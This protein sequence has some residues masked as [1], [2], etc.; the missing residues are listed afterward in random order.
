[1][2]IRL[3]VTTQHRA[4]GPVDVLVTA[5]EGT[6][7]EAL[8]GGLRAASGS[9]GSRFYI[10]DALLDEDTEL[11]TPPLLEGA[12]VTIDA[13]GAPS[14]PTSGLRL[15]V[16][17]GPD[18]G[19]VHLLGRG[20]ARL[21]RGADADVQVNDP[22][23]S[24]MHATLDIAP[25]WVTVA[26]LGSTN[27]TQL[28]R[29]PVH[30]EPTLLLPDAVLRIGESSLTIVS[31]AEAGGDPD[32]DGLGHLEVRRSPRQQI[33]PSP[34]HV[35]LPA[36]TG[37]RRRGRAAARRREASEQAEALA[38]AKARID[39][40]LTA[41]A[42]LRRAHDPDAAAL[43]V[44]ALERDRRL[45]E[46]R[47]NHP[48]AL[49]VRLGTADL[50]S[51]VTASTVDGGAIERL[52]V[53]D[54]PVTV[55]LR[56]TGPLGIV[57]A[58]V[59]A[60]GLVRSMLAQLAAAHSPSDL[61]IVVIS[62]GGG[63][64]W[65]FTRWLPHLLP[66]EAQDCRLLLGLD[67][68]QAAARAAELLGRVEFRRSE[69]G[70]RDGSGRWT[71]RLSVVLL[72]RG[73]DSEAPPG[74]VTGGRIPGGLQLPGLSA[75]EISR[76]L[77]AGPGVGVHAIC[78]AE[79][80]SALPAECDSRITITGEVGT[81][82]DVR[83]S[84][85][86][87][88]DNVVADLVS[89]AWAERFGRALAPLREATPGSR[90][91]RLPDQVRLLDL[92]KLDL[93]TPA[94]VAANWSAGG[95]VRATLGAGPQGPL[96]LDLDEDGPHV[97]VGGAPGAGKSEALRTLVTALAV[98]CPP[99]ELGLILIDGSARADGETEPGSSFAD[100]VTLPHVLAAFCELDAAKAEQAV[101]LLDHELERRAQ[102]RQ[103]QPAGTGR[104]SRPSTPAR[105]VVVVDEFVDLAERFPLLAGGVVA[106]ARN[107]RTL[108]VNVLAST[109]RPLE[110]VGQDGSGLFGQGGVCVALR[111]A[112]ARESTRLVGM[113]DAALL[114]DAPA[115][116]A[117]VRAPDGSVVPV[118][119]GQSSG[120]MA[121]TATL[122]PSVVKQ[123]WRE[124]GD[125]PARRGPGAEGGPTDLALLT[126]A[127]VKAADSRES[128]ANPQA[129]ASR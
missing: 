96:A 6:R 4:S 123:D 119:I 69:P 104:R 65:S 46:R 80:A 112:D 106:A 121:R 44:T 122:R 109:S 8:A 67:A 114:T 77:L 20:Q 37:G 10:G 124:L 110:A 103:D 28:D 126:G 40:A 19:G 63:A 85:Q 42:R 26:D 11:G 72:D 98:A 74:R 73:P 83:V 66:A 59:R 53:T 55:S 36:D 70:N 14:V 9:L 12:L 61:E 97:L 54:V 118:Q 29:T 25:D 89:P 94:K 101:A 76:L 58:R 95:S 31:Q 60:A 64:D 23:V 47:R 16:V 71:G 102:V 38:S 2:Q 120:R 30:A 88:V 33:S 49:S 90:G 62:P 41:E 108:G 125:P 24:R 129:T 86:P 111:V 127:I 34:V 82:L 116:R 39:V 115:G 15:H 113:H 50:P 27:G 45:W 87:E 21:G 22:D 56:E 1:M 32:P 93:V 105:L 107:A 81:R 5:P 79:Q 78:L 52:N 128:G 92:L 51:Q 91:P 48:D 57:G 84:G 35:A 7:F 18:A 17:G 13:P 68:E 75:A 100:C 99:E 43:L 117:Y 3:S